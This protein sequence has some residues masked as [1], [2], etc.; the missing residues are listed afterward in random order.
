MWTMAE[1]PLQNK[2]TITKDYNY[3]GKHLCQTYA[4]YAKQLP[5]WKVRFL[6]NPSL[7]PG[8]SAEGICIGVASCSNPV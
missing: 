6:L 7:L 5:V 3:I 2:T 4:T 1:N 8:R